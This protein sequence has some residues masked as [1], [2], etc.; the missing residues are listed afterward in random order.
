MTTRILADSVFGNAGQRCLA[1]SLAVT[2]GGVREA[3]TDAMAAAAAERVVGNGA[4]NV[5]LR[6]V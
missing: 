3:V 2:V 6:P 5:Q 4:C 1:A